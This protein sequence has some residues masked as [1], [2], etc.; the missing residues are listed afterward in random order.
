VPEEL[1]DLSQ[2]RV[3]WLRVRVGRDG[4]TRQVDVRRSSGSDVLDEA[5]IQA[6]SRFRWRPAQGARG[7]YEDW[8]ELG[9]TFG[10]RSV[11]S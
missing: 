4:S 6:A 5:A 3:V 11:D 2:P 10:Q 8:V 1:E 9:I 7:P